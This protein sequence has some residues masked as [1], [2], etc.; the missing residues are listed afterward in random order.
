M[1]FFCGSSIL[2][3]MEL[4]LTSFEKLKKDE[5][6]IDRIV[7][8]LCAMEEKCSYEQLL[9]LYAYCLVHEIS[10]HIESLPGWFEKDKKVWNIP[11]EKRKE[12]AAKAGL[13]LVFP[14]RRRFA[15]L[16]GLEKSA[17]RS[18]FHL[19]KL[20]LAYAREKGIEVLI[21]QSMELLEQRLFVPDPKKDGKQTPMKGHPVFI[22]QH[23]TATCCRGCLNKWHHVPKGR[24]L[25]GHEKQEVML[26]HKEWLEREMAR[27]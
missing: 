7:L 26:L 24:K 10:L 15:S 5:E 19:N 17:F 6:P 11:E 13:D 2:K 8:D 9:D 16:S 3:R 20:L 23:A 12:Q 18:S 14:F 25:L 1:A 21:R 27:K 4:Y 22:A